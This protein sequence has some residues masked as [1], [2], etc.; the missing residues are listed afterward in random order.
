ML[1]EKNLRVALKKTWFLA[2]ILTQDANVDK[3][4]IAQSKNTSSE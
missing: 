1:Y 3:K 2:G 4:A